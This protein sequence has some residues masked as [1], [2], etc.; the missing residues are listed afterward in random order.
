MAGS[1]TYY[2]VKK[3]DTLYAIA[4]QFDVGIVEIMAANPGIDTWLPKEGT[5]LTI[6]T[7]YVLPTVQRSGIVIDLSEL[8]LFYF[9]DPQTVMTFPLGIGMDGW[10]TPAGVTTIV[11]K[12]IH[13]TWTVPDSIR[14][15]KPDLPPSIPP[16]PDNPL[17]D[18]ALNLGWSGYLIHGTNRPYGIGRRSSH[19]CMRMY[20]EDIAALFNAVD[21][22]TQVTVID[23][24]YKLGW[25]E[26]MLYLQVTASQE[27]TDEI[28]GYKPLS[29][30][31]I[32]QVYGDVRQIA[33][34]ANKIDWSAVHQAVLWRAG[35]PVVIATRDKT[36]Q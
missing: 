14:Q 25:K 26:D 7:A 15:A 19:G 24:P 29:L 11:E 20:P 30:T 1:I 28:A 27:Q 35:I 13:P 23:A 9:P 12:R 34:S 5:I 6:P 16:G 36:V 22:G 32:P 3:K 18:Y 17:G 4:R 8:R 10:S 2:T 31:D 33:G 21:K